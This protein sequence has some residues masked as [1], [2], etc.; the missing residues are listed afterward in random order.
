MGGDVGGV[1]HGRR[2]G[3]HARQEG[4]HPTVLVLG[5][6]PQPQL[7]QVWTGP[8]S[9]GQS[10]HQLRGVGGLALVGSP[11][12]NHDVRIWK[13][14]EKPETTDIIQFIYIYLFR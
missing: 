10:L 14:M 6:L 9:E 1:Q 2:V 11:L 3:A 7:L 8:L 5:C 4:P 12:F 13:R